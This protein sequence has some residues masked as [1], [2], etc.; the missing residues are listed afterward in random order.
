[1]PAGP[2]DRRVLPVS[3]FLAL[4]PFVLTVALAS[5]GSAA[6]QA[7]DEDLARR[8]ANPLAE[9]ISVPLQTTWDRGL[10][11]DENGHQI[12]LTLQAVIPVPLNDRW[13]LITR[14][15]LPVIHQSGISSGTGRQFGLGDLE[16]SLF[17][18]PSTMT[19]GG[20]IW[21]VGPVVL[22]PA[23]TGHSLGEGKWGAGPSGA[24]IRQSG[25]WTSGVLSSH[26]WSVG[27]GD[28]RDAISRTLLQPLVAFTTKDELTF[29]LQ[30]ESTYDWEAC[31]W[32]IPIEAEA[33]KV[34]TLGTQAFEFG[35][36]VRYYARHPEDGPRGW[37]VT[38][39][40]TLLFPK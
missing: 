16:E 2:G 31:E 33:G 9:L 24:V 5:Q 11:P 4:A 8:L 40:M 10:G 27:G 35:G 19:A 18:S 38:A 21:G 22:L 36:G 3:R 7:P 34:A 12:T 15:I 1:M 39:T 13:H 6:G 17:F 30:T 23:A 37:G 14:T 25:A 26:T 20:V 29:T 32:T 28:H